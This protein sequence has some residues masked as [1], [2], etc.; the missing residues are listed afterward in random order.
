[1]LA[2]MMGDQGREALQM[3][4]RMERLRKLMGTTDCRNTAVV[5]RQEEGVFARS[6]SEE[7]IT[8]AIPFLDRHYQKGIYVMVK[9]MEMRRVLQ[10]GMLETRGKTDEPLAERRQ[11]LLGAIC[12]YLPDTEKNQLE[13]IMKMMMIQKMMGQEEK[14]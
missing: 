13:M 14:K 7:M 8:A 10:T 12:P 9:M 2:E 3:M 5:P 1:M 6:R 4:Q 11:Q